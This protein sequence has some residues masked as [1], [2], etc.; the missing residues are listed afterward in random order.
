MMPNRV[1]A[2]EECDATKLPFSGWG[3]SSTAADYIKKQPDITTR[4]LYTNT[5]CKLLRQ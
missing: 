3:H 5:V 4:L 2:V 1:V